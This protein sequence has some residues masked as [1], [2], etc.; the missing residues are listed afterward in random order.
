MFASAISG[1]FAPNFY[2]MN[3][4]VESIGR[5]YSHDISP[6]AKKFFAALGLPRRHALGSFSAPTVIDVSGIECTW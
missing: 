4:S 3:P 6:R 2:W 1:R 5:L